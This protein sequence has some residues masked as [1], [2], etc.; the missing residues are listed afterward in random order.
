MSKVS[1]NTDVTQ[2]KRKKCLLSATVSE[3]VAGLIYWISKILQSRE[4]AQERSIDRG[5]EQKK[6][7]EI[8]IY[9]WEKLVQAV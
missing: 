7:K 8:A 6:G 1:K 5:F 4:M 9:L 2:S 3:G